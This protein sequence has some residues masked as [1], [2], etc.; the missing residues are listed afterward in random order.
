MFCSTRGLCKTRKTLR[1]LI[2][3]DQKQIRN[4][5]YLQVHSK[6]VNGNTS[7]SP[8]ITRDEF[9]C[10]ASPVCAKLLASRR[11][12]GPPSLVEN[13]RV[14]SGKNACVASRR[15]PG[16]ALDNNRIQFKPPTIPPS[17]KPE[18]GGRRKQ[19]IKAAS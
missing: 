2:L 7:F 18:R 15:L 5:D 8:Q 12:P 19:V 13:R 14:P 1:F 6:K 17:P 3:L 11:L 4:R 9:L 16:F 10:K